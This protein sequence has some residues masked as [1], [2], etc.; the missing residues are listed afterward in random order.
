LTG[1][2]AGPLPRG[3]S[4]P[5][6]AETA[7]LLVGFAGTL[8]TVGGVGGWGVALST[9]ELAAHPLVLQV[10]STA[11][12]LGGPAMLLLAWWADRWVDRWLSVLIF[13]LVLFGPA[14]V[15]VGQ[16]ALGAKSL[17]L[18]V[19]YTPVP[20][21]AVYLLVRPLAVGVVAL[22]AIEFGA[23]LTFQRGYPAPIVEWLFLVATLVV[24]GS[25]FGALLSR[26][27]DEADRLS[28]LR[29]F[30]SPQV[31]EAVLSAGP[32]AILEP[33]RCRIAVLFCDLR[34][35]TRF[36]GISEPEEVVDVL[37][38]YLHTVG[39]LLD[40][41]GATVG[42]FAGDGI[43]AYFNDPVPCAAPADR[44]VELARR[45]AVALDG[46]V[47]VWERRGYRLS[48]GIGIAYGY[49]TLG[50]VGFE[51]RHDY[52]AVGS[53]VNLAARLSDHAGSGEILLDERTVDSVLGPIFVEPRMLDVKGF[54]DAVAAHRLLVAATSEVGTQAVAARV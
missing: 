40:E 36:S 13:G 23:V 32:S 43:M 48:Y 8:F 4:H 49:A 41:F 15:T 50:V 14:F 42:G 11:C 24:I 45:I 1:G 29:R 37:G 46:L 47:P 21:I 10:I 44:A 54:V 5:V 53:V 7:R 26:A 27:I 34:G 3:L 51:G 2:V 22:Q 39:A 52:T 28:R 31:A 6:P 17:V 25:T 38:D 19:M 16:Y 9:P 30:L 33:H 35:F 18:V 12:A 20:V